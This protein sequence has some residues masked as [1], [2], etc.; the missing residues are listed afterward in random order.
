LPGIEVVDEH[1]Y[2][3]TVETPHGH[4]IVRVQPLHDADALELR[5]RGVP[6]SLL[7]QISAT[8]RRV[9]DLAADPVKIVLAFRSDPLLGP[10]V[11]KWPGLRI[12]GAWDAFE[13]S[14]RAILGQ[15]VS[16]TTGRTLLHRLVARVGRSIAP[17]ENGLT[18]LFPKPDVL[19]ATDL[20]WL[21]IP[22]ARIRA[23]Q[24]LAKAV[25][26]GNITFQG[27][28]DEV[29]AAVA[30][31]PGIGNWTAQYIALRGLLEPDAFPAA[32]LVL[33]RAAGTRDVP[34]TARA[35]DELAERWRPWRGYAAM[36]LWRAA[37]SVRSGEPV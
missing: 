6:P 11:M 23:L 24:T 17:A 13:C 26:E 4:A 27:S 9:F 15:Q 31:L 35:L 37:R 25:A 29:A 36:Y 1:G 34:L 16:V 5:V 30:S 12:P 10:L 22:R 3:R 8:A 21:G 14:V 2:A 18:H 19:A 7:F 33:R 32:D 20:T 28:A